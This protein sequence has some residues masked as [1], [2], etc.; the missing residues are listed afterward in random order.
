M[1]VLGM[2]LDLKGRRLFRAVEAD[3]LTQNLIKALTDNGPRVRGLQKA[4]VRGIT[5]RGEQDRKVLDAGDVKA[6][7]WTFLLNQ[8]DPR[9]GELIAALKPL[10]E[11][12]GMADPASPLPYQTTN[13]D[14][15]GAWLEDNY[16]VLEL[17]GKK[18]PRYILIA[19]APD[20]VP[21]GFQSLLDT[22][23]NVGR[24]DFATT[25]DLAA[26]VAKLIRLEQAPDPVVAREAIVFAPDGGPT[27]PTH[28]SRRFMAEPIAD[29]IEKELKLAT[30]RVLGDKATKTG[31]KNALAAGKPAIVYTASHGLGALTEPL[32][33]QSRYNGAICCQ[34]SGPLTLDDL[35]AG[36]DVPANGGAFLEGAVFFQ[37]ACYGYGTPAMSEY[38]HW[39]LE[40]IGQETRNAERDFVAALPRKLLA[41]PRGPIAFIGHLDTAFLHGFADQDA[42]E[43]LDRWHNRVHPFV[44]AVRMLLEV[45]ASGLA[46][47]AM[48]ER[49]A[50]LNTLLTNTYDKIQRG[51]Q[52]W[53]PESQQRFLD[54]WITRG[55]AQNYMVFG[56]PAARLRL[57]AP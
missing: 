10:A 48:G 45:Q 21:F 8:D 35:L 42:P 27:D 15:W 47:Q 34:T 37:F 17:Q 29:L 28:F 39:L 14:E 5:F 46:M 36:D 43:T 53:T 56:D 2:G 19:G 49:Y 38:S 26:Y 4:T 3:A 9:K 54:S 6:A 25:D 31:L 55:D 1:Q 22:V 40:T 18:P 11:H 16:Y 51:R 52:Q 20:Q 24:V 7:G 50:T 41:H 12:R 13:P 57:P 23:A 33:I 30:T 32:E 44:S